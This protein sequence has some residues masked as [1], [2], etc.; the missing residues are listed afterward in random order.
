M[1]RVMSPWSDSILRTKVTLCQC[2]WK[3]FTQTHGA[4]TR[5]PASWATR[6]RKPQTTF[7]TVVKNVFLSDYFIVLIRCV[8]WCMLHF[9]KIENNMAFAQTCYIACSL[10]VLSGEFVYFKYVKFATKVHQKQKCTKV[11]KCLSLHTNKCTKL[12]Y[13]LNS[14]LIIHIKALYSFVTRTCF[15]TL[16]VI[17]REHTF[18]LAKIVD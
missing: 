17:I 6:R 10:M 12:I 7:F 15:D 2:P 3:A 18:F 13:Y 16:C 8:C 14:V 5:R 1:F 9:C 11:W 4:T